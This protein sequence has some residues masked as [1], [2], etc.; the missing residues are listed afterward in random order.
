MSKTKALPSKL[1]KSRLTLQPF[2]SKVLI[3]PEINSEITNGS[4]N[5]SGNFSKS[6]AQMLA[7]FLNSNFLDADVKIQSVT[8]TNI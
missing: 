5:L 4:F 8:Y 2:P 3:A 6:E 1:G 7:A